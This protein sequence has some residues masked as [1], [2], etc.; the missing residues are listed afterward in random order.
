MIQIYYGW[1]K[2]CVVIRKAIKLNNRSQQLYDA[3]RCK[4][5][6]AVAVE[7]SLLYS[8]H[9]PACIACSGGALTYGY[10]GGEVLSIRSTIV[11]SLS[12][13]FYRGY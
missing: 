8:M 12:S 5:E 6:H 2:A 1:D 9:L 10:A 3:R 4:S 11:M 13:D 7:H